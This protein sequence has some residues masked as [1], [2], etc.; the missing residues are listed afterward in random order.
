MKNAIA[1][2]STLAVLTGLAFSS[3]AELITFSV[4]GSTQANL[5]NGSET[6]A[7]DSV[8]GDSIFVINSEVPFGGIVDSELPVEGPS[9][10]DNPEPIFVS[11][12][13]A[14][15]G[16]SA[17]V[18]NAFSLSS[19]S[20]GE[21]SARA[22]VTQTYTLVN[23]SSSGEFLFNYFVERGVLSADCSGITG[24]IL[25]QSYSAEFDDEQQ[26]GDFI[27]SFCGDAINSDYAMASFSASINMYRGNS[28]TN[29]FSS[30]VSISSDANG[31]ELIENI[32]ESQVGTAIVGEQIQTLDPNEGLYIVESGLKSLSLG[33][34]LAGETITIE[35]NVSVSAFSIPMGPNM[36]NILGVPTVASA[37]FGDPTGFQNNGNSQPGS[38]SLARVPVPVS[39]PGNLL[40]LGLSVLALAFARRTKSAK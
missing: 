12:S 13:Y 3:H 7:E 27:P 14:N 31:V 10:T 21:A 33:E 28:M 34:I 4:S 20:I 16:V 5:L 39:A 22:E 18:G 40:I 15:S 32:R 24:P 29:L 25:A 1:K 35:Y 6:D 37:Q 38:S 30:E 17:S 23:G 2:L 9:E 11:T 36:P 19:F 8:S 26:G